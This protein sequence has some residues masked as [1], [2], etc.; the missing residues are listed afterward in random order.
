MTSSSVRKDTRTFHEWGS[1]L[2]TRC[3]EPPVIT[4]RPTQWQVHQARGQVPGVHLPPRA[5]VLWSCSGHTRGL[6]RRLGNGAVGTLSVQFYL[7]W[8]S[9]GTGQTRPRI[10]ASLPSPCVFWESYAS[11]SWGLFRWKI[12]AGRMQGAPAANRIRC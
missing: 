11:G 12:I 3:C 4:C 6:T 7:S 9:V 10:Q 1:H 5:E 2:H 8:S